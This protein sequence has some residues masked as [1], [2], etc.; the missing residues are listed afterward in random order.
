MYQE[1]SYKITSAL[2]KQNIIDVDDEEVYKYSIEVFISD[3]VYFLIA[4]LTA[5]LTKSL[6]ISAIYFVGFFSIRKFSGGYHAKTYMRCHFL[7]WLN[8]MLMIL[9]FKMLPTDCYRIVSYLFVLVSFICVFLFA[10]VDNENK[11]LDEYEKKKYAFIS[12]LIISFIVISVIVLSFTK[13]NSQYIFVGTFGVAS[14]SVSLIAE[15]IKQKGAINYEK[16]RKDNQKN[17]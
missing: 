7:S 3:I 14:V 16:H 13:A 10:P 2:E 1:L 15:K 9:M 5:I 8:Q 6:L 4:L 12:K 17:K 11:P